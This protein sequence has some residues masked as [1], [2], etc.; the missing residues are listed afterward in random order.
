MIYTSHMT[1]WRKFGQARKKRPLESAV[2]DKGVKER[3]VDDVRDF[4]MS[5][6][7]YTDRGI[8]YRRGYLLHGPPGSGKS[9]FIQA[10]AGELDYNICLVNLSE[11]GLTD[12]RLN[13]LLSNIPTR[14]LVLLENVDAAFNNRKQAD[15]TG[16]AGAN[17]TFSGLLNALDGVASSEERILF[18][19]TN[20]VEVLDPA[21][22]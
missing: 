2:L 14:L 3:I 20:H 9:S 7:W 19:T 5:S 1:D 11:R 18:L 13:H 21:H 22:G 4:L 16:Y 10:L 17:V 8:P 15:E 12:D 6:K